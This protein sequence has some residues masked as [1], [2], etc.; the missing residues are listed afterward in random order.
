MREWVVVAVLLPATASCSSGGASPGQTPADDAGADGTVNPYAGEDSG[1]GCDI[2]RYA[3]TYDAVWN[4]ILLHTCATEFCHGGS[5]DYLQ[6]SS[7]ST[8]YRSLVGAPAEGPMCATTGLLR[9]APFHPERSLMYLKV[10]SPPCGNKMPFL[11][12]NPSLDPCAVVQIRQWIAC[13]ALDGD[14]GCAGDAG[15]DSGGTDAAD[16][17]SEAGD[18]AG[19]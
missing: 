12:G 5:A 14:A 6:L 9:V 15:S 3:P 19:D 4:E 8:G 16:A 17:S 11:P 13:G 1:A 18:S 7:E 10:T 2:V